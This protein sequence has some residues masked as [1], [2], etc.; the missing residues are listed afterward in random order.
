MGNIPCLSCKFSFFQPI[1][2]ANSQEKDA[3]AKF[4]FSLLGVFFVCLLVG[5]LFNLA[6]RAITVNTLT[7]GVETI[8][9][10]AAY[11]PSQ[12]VSQRLNNGHYLSIR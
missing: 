2:S 8:E 11:M 10:A 6:Y 7:A 3:S 9:E 1:F 12:A 4:V 5:W